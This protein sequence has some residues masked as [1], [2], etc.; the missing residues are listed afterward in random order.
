[1]TLSRLAVGVSILCAIGLPST[2]VGAQVRDIDIA[3][4][5]GNHCIP[6]TPGVLTT[7]LIR[8]TFEQLEPPGISFRISGLPQ[9]WFTQLTLGPLVSV[10]I[11]DVFGT[12][13]QMSLST[14]DPTL[15]STLLYQVDVVP[16][17]T[18]PA[19]LS[20][21][22][23]AANPNP[24]ITCPCFLFGACEPVYGWLCLNPGPRAVVGGT[25]DCAVGLRTM[26]WT[27]VRRLYE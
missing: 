7:L 24:D 23:H 19:T 11:G 5:A 20:L 10:A 3:D 22:Q 16:A 21:L 26:S 2:Q 17:S 27:A 9:D 1:M 8:A 18:D 4:A 25:D 15:G 13:V 14:C 6:A 12:G